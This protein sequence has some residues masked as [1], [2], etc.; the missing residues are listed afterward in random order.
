MEYKNLPL[1]DA[2]IHVHSYSAEC[3]RVPFERH[4][5]IINE[6]FAKTDYD[7]VTLVATGFKG[8]FNIEKSGKV[9]L[10]DTPMGYYLKDK[11]KQKYYQLKSV[12]YRKSGSKG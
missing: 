6:L 5:E 1:I 8:S 11:C 7:A 9:N 10:L 3:L 4:E 2:H 12:G